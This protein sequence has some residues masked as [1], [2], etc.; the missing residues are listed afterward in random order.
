MDEGVGTGYAD[1]RMRLGTLNKGSVDTCSTDSETCF[2][3]TDRHIIRMAI[4]SINIAQC[5]GV[6]DAHTLD[7]IYFTAILHDIGKASIRSSVLNKPGPLDRE[8]RAHMETHATIGSSL[9]SSMPGWERVGQAVRAHHEWW[10]GTGYPDRLREEEI[11]FVA[12]IVAIA[13][14]LD[15]MTSRRP[16]RQP[17]PLPAALL[18]I[19][20]ESGTH[21]DPTLVEAFLKPPLTHWMHLHREVNQHTSWSLL[22]LH[23]W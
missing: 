3:L 17:L 5:C 15:A 18:H 1:F 11:P 4:Y 10:D 13:D 6:D 16:Y 9:V 23:T 8:E 2:D 14:V 22:H 7:E 19:Q 12:R 20:K 21:F